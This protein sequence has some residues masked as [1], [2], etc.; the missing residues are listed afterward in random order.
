[1]LVIPYTSKTIHLQIYPHVR[2][3]DVLSMND[4]RVHGFPGLNRP[5][6]AVTRILV[7]GG[8]IPTDIN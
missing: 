5:K 2:S 1:M 4:G 6:M 8:F 7:H 3:D